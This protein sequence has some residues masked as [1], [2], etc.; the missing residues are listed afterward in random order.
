MI[1]NEKYRVR[2]IP[3]RIDE[4]NE[5]FKRKFTYVCMTVRFMIFLGCSLQSIFK[6]GYCK[7][8]QGRVNFTLWTKKNYHQ[9]YLQ[10]KVEKWAKFIQIGSWF[11][12]NGIQRLLKK[13]CKGK[14]GRISSF[15]LFVSTWCHNNILLLIS[16]R[17]AFPVQ[18]S[19]MLLKPSDQP[20]MRT[21]SGIMW[22]Y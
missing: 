4:K 13:E 2:V 21:G 1:K 20:L 10:K 8:E 11:K 19:L 15:M 17:S 5:T 7:T 12:T 22:V 14:R 16:H 9:N 18:C 3:D 6:D